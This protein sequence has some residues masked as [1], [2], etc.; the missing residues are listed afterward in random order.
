MEEGRPRAV[1]VEDL[2][3]DAIE[4]ISIVAHHQ[5]GPGKSQRRLLEGAQRREVE[6]VGG[7]VEDQDVAAGAEELSQQY[8]VA[9]A[10]DSLPTS[11]CFIA[12]GKRSWSRKVSI[13]TIRSPTRT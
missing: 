1:E 9:L 5:Y 2:G 7:L 8:A 13:R 3:R 12:P 6:V 10:P 4:E 11:W